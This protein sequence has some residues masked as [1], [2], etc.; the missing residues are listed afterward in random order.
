MNFTIGFV[1]SFIY[2]V[3]SL[4]SLV[5]SY[6]PDAFTGG[7][8][9]LVA[10]FAAGSMVAGIIFSMYAGTA[11]TV[12]GG[13]YM[14]AKSQQARLEGQQGRRPGRLRQGRPHYD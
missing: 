12:G 10:F 8:F 9:F 5:L 4:F 11:A 14:L 6:E 13:L 2:F 3:F 1:F 7:L